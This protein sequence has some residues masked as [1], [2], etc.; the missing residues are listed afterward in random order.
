MKISKKEVE[1]FLPHRNPFLFVD[2]IEDLKVPEG[3]RAI[4][5][6]TPRDLVGA[7]ITAYFTVDPKLVILEGHFPGNPIFP[8]VIHVEMMAQASAFMSIALTGFKMDGVKVDTKLL[9]VDKARFRMPV[10][11]GMKLKIV[12]TLTQSRGIYNFYTCHVYHGEEL[13][14]DADIFAALKFE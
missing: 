1:A 12:S 4:A 3:F 5:K 14:A 11:P 13:I 7:E 10:V 2:T 9:G 6:P 8:G